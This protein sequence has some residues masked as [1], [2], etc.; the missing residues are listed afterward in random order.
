ML[1]NKKKIIFTVL[2]F[3]LLFFVFNVNTAKAVGASNPC[4]SFCEADE[5]C[6]LLKA[7]EDGFDD[8]CRV[9]GVKSDGE[10]WCS[11]CQCTYVDLTKN[12]NVVCECMCQDTNSVTDCHTGGLFRSWR[13]AVCSCCGDC[14][15]ND[16]LYIGVSV[17]ELILKYLGVI[18]LFIFV[19][20][21][22]IWITSGGSKEK[23]KKGVAIIK[24]AII[25][26]IIVITAFLVVRVIMR[27]MLGVDPE[28]LPKSS[29]REYRIS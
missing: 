12:K 14:T 22:I 20:G 18:A 3:G 24:G 25:G 16:L 29:N 13:T 28:Y 8:G 10:A 23:V 27:D 15:L 5:N 1:N 4:K 26:M 11:C 7:G 21:G 2:I 19:L 9:I 17:A 6:P